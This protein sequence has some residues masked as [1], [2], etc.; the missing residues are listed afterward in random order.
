MTFSWYERMPTRKEFVRKGEAIDFRIVARYMVDRV[1][2]TNGT[3]RSVRSWESEYQRDLRNLS[4]THTLLALSL[5]LGFVRFCDSP[6]T[7]IYCMDRDPKFSIWIIT[8]NRQV[9]R[10]VSIYVF[11]CVLVKSLCDTNIVHIGIRFVC[12]VHRWKVSK[13]GDEH[14]WS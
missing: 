1:W 9:H 14:N 13:E 12:Q 6:S 11:R 2:E 5:S 3:I 4:I 8:L 10:D 7:S